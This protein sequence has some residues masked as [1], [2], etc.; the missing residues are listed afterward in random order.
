MRREE[1]LGKEVGG[2]EGPLK[3]NLLDEA[4]AVGGDMVGGVGRRERMGAC[5]DGWMEG[6]DGRTDQRQTSGRVSL[7]GLN[8]SALLWSKGAT[9]RPRDPHFSR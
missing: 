9:R 1:A 2:A 5:G 6:R 7:A 4:E 8:R 3:A